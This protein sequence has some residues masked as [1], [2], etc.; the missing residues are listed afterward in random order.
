M[1]VSKDSRYIDGP[2]QQIKNKTTG[3]YTWAVYRTFAGSV[4]IKY[5]DYTWVYG[6]RIDYLAA[7]YLGDSKLW[8]KI[9]DINPTLDDPF[10]IQP[11][12]KIRIPKR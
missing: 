12:T 4:L 9:M 7:V 2:A 10:N 3:L 11:G 8:W 5:I 6:D 1:S